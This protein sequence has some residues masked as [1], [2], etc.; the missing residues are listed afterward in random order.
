MIG[1]GSISLRNPFFVRLL[2]PRNSFRTLVEPG[3]AKLC[4][5]LLLIFVAGA[6]A[7]PSA[8]GYQASPDWLREA[9]PHAGGGYD[10]GAA[11]SMSVANFMSVSGARV[12]MRTI[13]R[14]RQHCYRVTVPTRDNNKC[15]ALMQAVPA[16]YC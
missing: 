13:Y 12:L 10:M 6:S 14:N 15:L 11:N 16:P 7:P 9:T 3:P 2:T 4:L 8:V 5:R 1:S